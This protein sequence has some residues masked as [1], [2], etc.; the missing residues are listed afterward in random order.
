MFLQVR[1]EV[2]LSGSSR[3]NELTLERGGT[4]LEGSEMQEFASVGRRIDRKSRVLVSEATIHN[5]PKWLAYFLAR[6]GRLEAVLLAHSGNLA[7]VLSRFVDST[8]PSS[9]KSCRGRHVVIRCLAIET[10]DLSARNGLE[11]ETGSVRS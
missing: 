11:P 4:S 3:P 6:I 7:A 8:M 2:L 9:S 10:R 5:P 1:I